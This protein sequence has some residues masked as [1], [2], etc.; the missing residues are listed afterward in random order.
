MKH[1]LNLILEPKKAKW[2]AKWEKLRLAE[3]D[4]FVEKSIDQV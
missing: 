1:G 3:L 2:E 4:L